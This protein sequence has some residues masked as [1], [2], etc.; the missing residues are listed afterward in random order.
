MYA[1]MYA[2]D[3]I[4]CMYVCMHVCMGCHE[5]LQTAIHAASGRFHRPDSQS[6]CM[7]A[8]M[9]VYMYLC[10]YVECDMISST[11]DIHATS[12]S[13][14]YTHRQYACMY[15]CM[16]VCICVYMLSV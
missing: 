2:W 1:C 16:Y 13:H 7:H 5:L 10:V 3:V 9:Y 8:C 15:V 14:S 12:A 4:V 11:R 6:V